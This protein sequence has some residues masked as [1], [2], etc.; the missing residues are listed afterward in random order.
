LIIESIEQLKIPTDSVIV[1]GAAPCKCAA[2]S[3]AL[4]IAFSILIDN[5]NKYSIGK[6]ELTVNYFCDSKNII[7][8]FI[9]KGIGISREN[10]KK[11]FKKFQRIYHPNTP[12]VKGTGLG[13]YLAREIL[14][15]HGGKIS[16]FSEGENKGATFRLQL[17]I[18]P[19]SK[20][21]YLKS[22][23]KISRTNQTL[24]I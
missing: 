21:R 9:D 5:A 14:R 23:L 10:Q 22:L 2:D 8:E 19:K 1:K 18:Y 24:E 20:E 16:V 15:H 6:L 7:I 11:I 13:L 4:K 17:P 12:N 3:D